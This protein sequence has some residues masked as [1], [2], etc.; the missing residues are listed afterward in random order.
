MPRRKALLLKFFCST[1]CPDIIRRADSTRFRVRGNFLITVFLVVLFSTAPESH[2]HEQHP[3]PVRM[4]LSSEAY[5][6]LL[7]FDVPALMLSETLNHLDPKEAADQLRGL[8]PE[9]REQALSQ[10][11]R[12]FRINLKVEIDGQRQTPEIEL[13]S[14]EAGPL[15]RLGDANSAF[16]VRIA[17]DVPGGAREMKLSPGRAIGI[18]ELETVDTAG[19]PMRR[20]T[21]PGGMEGEPIE[22]PREGEPSASTMGASATKF[23]GTH[24]LLGLRGLVTTGGGTLL[25]LGALLLP[26]IGWRQ[27]SGQFGAFMAALV[28]TLGLTGLGHLHVPDRIVGPLAVGS[29][30]LLALESLIV[31]GFRVW[32]PSL[33]FALGGI[34]GV[35][36][37][38]A[39][40][41]ASP[42]QGAASS[43]PELALF[44]YGMGAAAG[45][46][47]FATGGWGALWVMRRHSGMTRG[48]GRVLCGMIL[49]IA[50]CWTGIRIF[51]S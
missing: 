35:T 37:A 8:R 49:G 6:L 29:A 27:T 34:H 13:P 21:V 25:F 38:D 2:A 50:I 39:Y 31:D 46:L 1:N 24:F 17:G 44:V 23:V 43:R 18:L 14:F 30:G 48:Y 16:Q 9:A 42:G 26:A 41:A 20:E 3:V 45:L 12:F 11:E 36:L 15:G 7:D 47:L 5:E 10:A 4:I 32:R 22:I 19:L 40:V 51:G 33:V 28:V